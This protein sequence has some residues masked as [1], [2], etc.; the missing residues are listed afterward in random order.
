MWQQAGRAGRSG[1]ESL[2]V[3]V[4]G[5]DQLDQWLMRHPDEV[6]NRPPETAVI[7]PSNSFI[8]DP[9]IACAAYE[10][11]ITHDD[12]KFWPD[13]ID[14]SV[15][16]LARRDLLVTRQIDRTP[17]ALWAGPGL[18]SRGIGLRSGSSREF[19]IV[20]AA[21]GSMVGTVDEDRAA[22]TVHLGAVYLHRGETWRVVGYDA[23]ELTAVVEPTEGDEYTQARS[24]TD[25]RVVGVDSRQQVGPL[26]LMLGAV[27]VTS[28]VTGYQRRDRRSRRVL[29]NEDLELEPQRL[30][31]RAFWYMLDVDQ[32]QRA[33]VDMADLA[34]AL[35]GAEHAM[36]AMLPL[37]TI[38]DRWDVGG[39]ST[40][41]HPDTGSPSIFIY[42]GY[43]GGTGIAELGYAV[44]GRHLI[45]TH[46]LVSLCGC[47]SGCPS[48]I[49]SPK[50]GNGNEPLDKAGASA[51]L[52][53][54]SD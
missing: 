10:L 6:F 20:A 4:A 23:D 43:Q 29:A 37:F 21:D 1:Q 24:S 7:N 40:V 27:E 32:C 34:G 22:A 15:T 44:A 46:D 36:I 19:K 31:T 18:P 49:V 38:C 53:L 12:A 47:S 28:Q 51:L 42:D 39:V 8:C 14:E 5:Q 16:R 48:C 54:G 30:Q 45:A 9:H 2:T 25:I 35:H 50:C 52:R 17:A 26:E 41:I 11:P 13:T 3:L 33:G